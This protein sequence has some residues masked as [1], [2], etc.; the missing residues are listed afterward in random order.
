MHLDFFDLHEF[1]FFKPE[2]PVIQENLNEPA[3]MSS[4]VRTKTSKT[5][6]VDS[7]ESRKSEKQPDKSH[8]LE[9]PNKIQQAD[10]LDKSDMGSQLV[11][12]TDEHRS[13][14]DLHLFKREDFLDYSLRLSNRLENV[15]KSEFY[16]DFMENFLSGITQSMSIDSVKRLQATLQAT[17]LRKQSEER[18]K[19]AKAKSKKYAKP[20]LRTVRRVDYEAFEVDDDDFDQDVDYDDDFI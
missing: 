11:N 16:P 18:E 20:Q 9:E 3:K 5:K 7:D 8:K 14:D 17:Y 19:K 4:T 6:N 2:T 15:S 1:L 13:L 12:K 10:Q